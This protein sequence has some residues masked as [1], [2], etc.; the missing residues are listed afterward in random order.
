MQH[1][2]APNVEEIFLSALEI[3]GR[4]SRSSYLDKICGND[5]LRRHV[6]RLLALDA[7]ASGFLESPAPNPTMTVDPSPLSEGPGTLIGPY[8]LMEQIGEGGMGVVYVAEQSQP[9]RR[10]VALKISKPGMDT[11]QVVA[12]FEAERQALAMMDHPNIAK[13]HDAGTTSPP[14]EGGVRGGGRPYFVMELVRGVPITEY[15]DR[16]QLSIPERL[17]LFVLVC[18]A[19]QHAH[20]K[21]I[22]H[23][24]LKPSNILVTVIDGAAVPK[25]IDFGVAKATGQRLTDKT[26]TAPF[27]SET[28]R[29]AAFDEMRRMIREVEPQTPSTRLNSLGETL[30][31]VSARRGSDPRQ[32][33]RM[34]RGELDWIVMKALEKDRRR[35]YETAND[36]AADV[37]RYLTNQPVDA[38]PPAAG[39]RLRKFVRRNKGPVAAGLAL[40]ALLV[41]G[42]VG[43]SIGLARALRAEHSATL[44]AGRARNAEVL[45]TDRLVEVTKEKERANAAERQ[46]KEEAAVARAVSD[47]IQNDL[48]AEASPDN[49]VRAKKVTVAELLNRAAVRIAGKFAQQP[50]IE[51]EIRRTIG[52]TYRALNNDSA[53]RQQLE[54]AWATCRNA[55][56]EEDLNSLQILTD[57]ALLDMAQGRVR[58]AEQGFDKVLKVRRS[59]LGEENPDTLE[60]MIHL[61]EAYRRLG[62]RADAGSLLDETLKI[63]RC[64]L[65]EENAD[66][67][68]PMIHLAEVFRG[69]GRRADAESLFV[70]TL[71]VSRRAR[72]EEHVATLMTMN[73]LARAYWLAKKLDRSIPLYEEMV[74]KCLAR[75]GPDQFQTIH[76]MLNLGINYR[77]AGRLP[78]AVAKLELAWEWERKRRGLMVDPLAYLPM[79]LADAY[80]RAGRSASSD[81][82]YRAALK[83][84]RERHGEA[85]EGE[86]DALAAIGMHLLEQQKYADAEPLLR[87]CLMVREQNQP[88]DWRTFNTKSMLGGSLLGQKKY[89]EAEP[90]LLAG[91]EGMKQRE[92]TIPHQ[93]NVHLTEAI[94]RLVQLYEVTGKTDETNAVAQEAV[95]DEVREA[96]KDEEQLKS[97]FTP[98]G[99]VQSHPY[100]EGQGSLLGHDPA[101]GAPKSKA[102]RILVTDVSAPPWPK[103]SARGAGIPISGERR[104]GA[105]AGDRSGRPPPRA[106][107]AG[108]R[109]RR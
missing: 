52:N 56:G 78:E 102:M 92:D 28:L 22:I 7:R 5:E 19:V 39:Y 89:T 91:Y 53:A 100:C 46:A 42:T 9:V 8:K 65:E 31:T 55:L 105:R 57:L 103:R 86:S 43:T 58:E 25:V 83:A 23:R 18:R 14:C 21:G 32:L 37:M 79:T 47:F 38:C 29:R 70:K 2:T 88:D 60:S 61:A 107:R 84:A 64:V 16:E 13:V 34:V 48:L 85:S 51:A 45:A 12:R 17:D 108:K 82:L 62:R 20:Q 11:K 41:L 94:E 30:T 24:D 72:G 95:H 93:G 26:G 6:E 4:E 96:R 36:F 81:P 50:R 71:E 98:V 33:N 15:C 75:S 104:D 80:D 3:E 99:W 101:Y 35:R 67:L 59:K 66:T 69:L 27:D 77:D 54:R 68:A 73:N 63:S 109:E 87:E 90:L 106:G 97:I 40:A 44:A 74:T 1:R 76:A 49:N 10:K